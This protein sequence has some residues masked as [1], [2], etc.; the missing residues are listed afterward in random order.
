MLDPQPVLPQ[1][2][3][4]LAATLPLYDNELLVAVD[5]LQIDSASFKQLRDSC[6]S[7]AEVAAMVEKIV[8]ERGKMSN[9]VTGSGGMLLGTIVDVGPSYTGLQ[10]RLGDRIATLVSLTATPL[11]LT[12]VLAVDLRRERLKVKGH[13]ILFSS[14]IFSVLPKDLDEE[15]CLSALDICGA[16]AR[17]VR[18]VNREATVFILGLGKAGI[19]TLAALRQKYGKDIR[20]L[21]ADLNA[22]SVEFCQ[23]NYEGEYHVLNAREP[24]KVMDW[25]MAVSGGADYSVN[26]ANVSDTE[27]AT[28]L[29]TKNG[30]RCLFFGMAT[31]FQKAT[32]G[33]ESVGRDVEL[34]MGNGF[35]S[36]HASFI[37][38]LLREDAS[39]AKYFSGQVTT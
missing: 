30:G 15:I 1:A 5:A 23:K 24:L 34:I 8:S 11:H 12:E 13:A 39:L 19:S 38:Q 36:G 20:I 16:P 17:V 14:H 10:T 26:A 7:E 22:A 32:L 6:G 37:Y 25:V 3:A 21:G 29:A 2:A 28:I 35:C 9:P 18:E 33:A 27:M 31:N 4:K